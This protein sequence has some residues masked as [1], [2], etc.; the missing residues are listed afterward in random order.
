MIEAIAARRFTLDGAAYA[1][2]D[3]LAL[4]DNQFADLEGAGLVAIALKAKDIADPGNNR[5]SGHNR[6]AK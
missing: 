5:P 1:Q 3:A 6:K 4:S 2:G